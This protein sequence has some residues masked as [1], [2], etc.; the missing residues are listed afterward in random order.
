[1]GRALEQD[2]ASSRRGHSPQSVT[3]VIRLLELLAADPEPHSLAD[4]ARGLDTPKSSLAALLRGLAEE[5]I[6]VPSDGAWQL[7]PGAF[8]LGSA[9]VEARRQL[10]SS[11]LVRDGMRRLADRTGETVL[12]GVAEPDSGTM[13]YVDVVES[14]HAVRFAVSMGERR[15]LYATAGGR[16]LLAARGDAECA[17]YFEALRTNALTA[18]TVTDKRR[19]AA[20]VED[21]RQTGIA[22]TVDQLAEGVAGTA[23]VIRKPGGEVLGALILGAPTSRFAGRERELADLVRKEAAAISRSLGYRGQAAG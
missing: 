11:D 20:A 15:V 10:Q 22:Q 18:E 13:I 3:R 5:D 6:V 17:A 16:A 14:R 2:K 23:A 1:M 4:L 9:I 12:L 7:G 21:V 19:L 8:G